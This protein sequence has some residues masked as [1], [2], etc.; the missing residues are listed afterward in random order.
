MNSTV[1]H[2]AQEYVV[3]QAQ[4]SFCRSCQKLIVWQVSNRT[5]KRYPTDAKEQMN[6]PAPVRFVTSRTWF[7]DCVPAPSSQPPLLPPQPVILAVYSPSGPSKAAKMR[8]MKSFLDQASEPQLRLA[9]TAIFNRQTRT[10]QAH[11]VTSEHNSIGF[12]GSDAEIL[13]NIHKAA[14]KYKGLRG[15][16][17]DLIR[18]KMKKYS[19]QLVAALEGKE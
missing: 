9:L 17:V 8:A 13:S 7:H 4:L 11:D 5:G 14:T 15:K 16:Q 2:P 1:Q 6:P 10:E 3:N 12:T 19:R 18:R